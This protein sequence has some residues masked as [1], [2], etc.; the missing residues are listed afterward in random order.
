MGMSKDLVIVYITVCIDMLGMSFITPI[1]PAFAEKLGSSGLELGVFYSSYA[2]TQ[3]FSAYIMGTLS[4]KY[5]RKLFLILSLVGSVT[6]PVLQSFS[7]S[8]WMFTLFRAYTGL[9]GGSMTIGLASI[10]D[11][12]PAEERGPYLSRLGGFTAGVYLFGPAIGGFLSSYYL[13]APFWAA[14]AFAFIISIF[15]IFCL[16]ETNPKVIKKNDLIQK[17]KELLKNTALSN[18]ESIEL[19]KINNELFELNKKKTVEQKNKAKIRWN[20]S[21]IICLIIR[22]MNES[23]CTIFSGY[24]GLYIIANLNATSFEFSLLLTCTGATCFLVQSFLLPFLQNNL[25]INTV[26]IALLGAIIALGGAIAM[27]F[28]PNVWL[29]ILFTVIM[30]VGFSIVQPIPVIVLSVQAPQESQGQ[31]LSIGTIILQVNYILIPTIWGIFYDLSPFYTILSESIF[32][33]LSVF[34]VLILFCVPGGKDCAKVKKTDEEKSDTKEK[35]TDTKEEPKETQVNVNIPQ[36]TPKESTD[37]TN[38]TPITDNTENISST[39]DTTTTPQIS[40]PV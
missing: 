2:F 19:D 8:M 14:S 5:G 7:T 37:N 11:V 33:I 39:P 20:A 34:S 12:V 31:A 24:Y 3:I 26:V 27:P 38:I 29:G 9:L 1:I 32:G 36:E 40:S 17:K 16:K 13:E 28:A 15:A 23:I 4:D 10:A 25:K 6:G 22:F 30:I 35:T 18:E 21:M